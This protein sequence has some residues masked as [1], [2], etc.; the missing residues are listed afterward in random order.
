MEMG[1]DSEFVDIEGEG[2]EEIGSEANYRHSRKRRYP[3]VIEMSS[4]AACL[5]DVSGIWR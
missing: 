3:Q 5:V 4:H 1:S 2:F